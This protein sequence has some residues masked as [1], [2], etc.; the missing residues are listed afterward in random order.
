MRELGLLRAR[1]LASGA[2]R[3]PEP[4]Q[5]FLGAKC[6]MYTAAPRT[7]S[8]ETTSLMSGEAAPGFGL[9]EI[10]AQVRGEGIPCRA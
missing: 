1:R 7:G 10:S 4:G 2:E 8:V 5:L 9:P 6:G 3:F